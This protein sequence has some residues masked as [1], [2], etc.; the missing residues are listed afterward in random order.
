[1][2]KIFIISLCCIFAI[3]INAARVDSVY[4]QSKSMNIKVKTLVIVP[5]NSLFD[6]A[7][8]RPVIYLLHGYDGNERQ[9]L[10]IKQN[11]P[12]IADEKGIIF[13][14]PDGKNSWYFN[15]PV[16]KSSK[17]ETFIASEL[18]AC[19]DSTYKTVND[20][21]GRAITG[22]SMGGHGALYNA[23]RH[24]DVFG[25]AGSMS[26]AVAISSR[27]NNYGLVKL[28]G[29]INEHPENWKNNSVISQ[30]QHI[31]DG[32]LEIII[33]CGKDD[34]CFPLNESLHDALNKNGISHDYTVRA[35]KHDYIYW[36]SAIDY[37]ILFFL[38][39]FSK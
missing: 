15:S 30:V 26:G 10:K 12:Q 5:E 34:F 21:T 13:V 27:G 28:L 22:F 37:H 39:Y 24:K 16:D 9:W 7:P 19:I 38:K 23:F 4:V 6:T 14:L 17:Y 11:L 32:D 33:D 3:S 29:D 18:I 31:K 8:R 35:G 20:R 25:A 2:K 36:K 1:M